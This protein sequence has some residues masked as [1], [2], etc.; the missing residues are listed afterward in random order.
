MNTS[1]NAKS[2]TNGSKPTIGR[3]QLLK[4]TA[5]AG[6]GLTVLPSG[7]LAGPDA[8]SNKLGI[9]MIG[10]GGRARA[11]F[12]AVKEENVVALCDVDENTLATAAKTFPDAKHYVDWRKC[13]E[14][15]DIDAVVCCTTDHT[16]AFISNWA[17]NRGL[18]VYCEKP[19]A[20][21][22]HEARVVRAN[23]MK[24]KNKLA[25]QVGMQR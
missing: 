6:A 10:A 9:A 25:T 18:H 12:N 11:H 19:L 15:K 1:S 24:N 4:S 2:N 3:R 16:H 20:N 5:V 22:V 8:P 7:L 21:C 23:Y 17:L 13:I 14:Q